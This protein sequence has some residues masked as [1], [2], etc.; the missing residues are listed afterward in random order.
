MSLFFCL[1]FC[2]VSIPTTLFMFELSLFPVVKGG[3]MH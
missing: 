3:G 2:L 1:F